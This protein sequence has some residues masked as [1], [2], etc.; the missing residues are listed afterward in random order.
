LIT[1]TD[2][3]NNVLWFNY[4]PLNRLIEKRQANSGGNRLA[5]YT[6]DQGAN[7][8]GHR[9]SLSDL[10]GNTAWSYDLRGR[11]TQETKVIS[12]TGGGTFVTQWTYDSMD[13]PVWMKYPGGASGQIG[14]QV[15]LAYNNAGLLNSVIGASR[16]VS[17]T[18]YDAAGRVELRVLG[19]TVLQQDYVYYPWTTYKGNGRLQQLKTGTLTP[20]NPTALQDL[21]YTYDAVGNV[22]TIA[23][24]KAGGTQTQTFHY[25]GLDRLL[26]ATASGG[27]G[28]T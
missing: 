12:G 27:A 11:M 16:Y 15:T 7:G 28:G 9:T 21:R 4:D 8:I 24:L 14:E 1:Q 5:G 20:N 6:Y 18:T 3:L 13:R 10:S 25:D 23:D 2:A 17:S 19:S 22:L 26:D